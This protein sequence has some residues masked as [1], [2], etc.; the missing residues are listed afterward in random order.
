MDGKVA[1]IHTWSALCC[2]Y[3]SRSD[4]RFYSNKQRCLHSQACKISATIE[5]ICGRK[6]TMPAGLIQA[7]KA[8]TAR[9]AV[10][11]K[12]R[13]PS[14]CDSSSCHAWAPCLHRRTDSS[15]R[16][17]L[18]ASVSGIAISWRLA[19]YHFLPL[20]RAPMEIGDD[21]YIGANCQLAGCTIGQAVIIGDNACIVRLI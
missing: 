20:H 18:S 12:Q 1:V 6:S 11:C 9:F 10:H 2:R 7:Q 17:F 16:F 4:R 13:R 21:S 8:H 19:G 15:L 3:G 14:G 5:C